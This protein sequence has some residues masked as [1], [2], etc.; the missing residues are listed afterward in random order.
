M[1]STN[2]AAASVASVALLP[3]PDRDVTGADR[4][5]NDKPAGSP[6][7]A[8][9]LVL[10]MA[11]AAVL[12][13]LAIVVAYLDGWPFVIFWALAAIAVHVEWS[14]MI[15]GRGQTAR[16][17]VGAAIL[18][19]AAIA[20]PVLSGPAGMVAKP[21][22]VIALT[23]AIGVIAVGVPVIAAMAS[24]RRGFAAFGLVYA[25][26]LVIAPLVM[27]R[28]HDFGFAA[29]VFLF[30]V[31]WATDIGGYFAGRLIGGPKL[32]PR[33]SPKKTWAGALGGAGAALLSAVA[34][35]LAF[36]VDP[37]VPAVLALVLSAVSQA[38]DLFESAIKRR[39]GIKDAG[40]IIP[41]HGGVM[42]RLDGFVA[43]AAL[44]AVIGVV[45]AGADAAGHGLLLW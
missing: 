23:T 31:V 3:E 15:G 20:V 42:D 8:S 25:G 1:R 32:W 18:A 26:A 19:I 22:V 2:S 36:G 27:R 35:A 38:G 43:A 4:A 44:A 39:F 13:P 21:V 34:V 6:K 24:E 33:V 11:S 29:L 28:D 45:R 16:A 7:P 9:D 30:A 5:R 40:S 37:F 12:A 17:V 41:G 10:R 14:R